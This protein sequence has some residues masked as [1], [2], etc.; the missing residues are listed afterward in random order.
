M[1]RGGTLWMGLGRCRGGSVKEASKDVDKLGSIGRAVGTTWSL[2]WISLI[3]VGSGGENAEEPWK[4]AGLA[5]F[6]SVLSC[7]D[8]HLPSSL[9]GLSTFPMRFTRSP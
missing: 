5:T 3:L 2:T 6:L 7:A 1:D 8:S 4:R 9:Q